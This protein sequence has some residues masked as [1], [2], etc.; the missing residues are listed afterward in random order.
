MAPTSSPN[1]KSDN[2]FLIPLDTE[3][4]WFR[5]H[6]LFQDLLQ[7]QLKQRCSTKEIAALHLRASEWFAKNGLIDEALQHAITANSIPYAVKLVEQHRYDLM[8]REQWNRLER[9][10]KMLPPET[11]RKIRYCL[12]HRA[13]IYEHRGQIP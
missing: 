1:C 11:V 4:G 12:L 6:H 5:Y 13:Y 8:N 9:L 10:L 3:N 7:N 2:L